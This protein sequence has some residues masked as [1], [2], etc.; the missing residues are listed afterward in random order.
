MFV[1][2]Y[3]EAN[4][5]FSNHSWRTWTERQKGAFLYSIFLPY[6]FFSSTCNFNRTPKKIYFSPKHFWWGIFSERTKYPLLR[7]PTSLQ[8]TFIL[9]CMKC[10]KSE[11]ESERSNFIVVWLQLLSRSIGINS[12]L[13]VNPWMPIQVLSTGYLTR[14]K[15]HGGVDLLCESY[16]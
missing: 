9:I 2:P 15:T 5:T 11:C 10:N 6:I 3:L 14:S 4:L 7:E 1:L 12:L 8:K 16:W 13:T